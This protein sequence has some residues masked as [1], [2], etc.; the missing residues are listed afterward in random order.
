VSIKELKTP[1][2]A[3]LYAFMESWVYFNSNVTVKLAVQWCLWGG[4]LAGNSKRHD[5]LLASAEDLKLPGGFLMTEMHHGSNTRALETTATFDPATG[6]FVINTPHPGARKFWIGGTANDAHMGTVFARLIMPNGEDKGLHAF[7]VPL[8]N[9]TTMQLVSGVSIWDCGMKMGLNGVDNGCI[10]FDHVRVPRESLMNS[11]ADVDAAGR[12]VCDT[13]PDTRFGRTISE[14]SG[15]RV[16]ISGG[17]IVAEKTCLTIALRWAAQRKQFGP[18]NKDEVSILTYPTLQR[19]LL[20]PLCRVLV[21]DIVH[22]TVTDIYVHRH[23]AQGAPSAVVHALTAGLKAVNTW[24]MV[25][26]V[27]ACRESMG[28]QGF[29]S[30]NRVSEYVDDTHTFVTFE[31]VN[32]VLMQQVSR[33][34]LSQNKKKGAASTSNKPGVSVSADICAYGLFTDVAFVDFLLKQRENQLVAELQRRLSASKDSWATWTAELVL[35]ER[36]AF[37]FMD[38]YFHSTVREFAES[39]KCPA[40]VRPVLLHALRVTSLNAILK[41]F[42]TFA[43]LGYLPSRFTVQQADDVL[44]RLLLDVAPV[45]LDITE[46]FAVPEKCLPRADLCEL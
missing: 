10:Q 9:P 18:P 46:A 20:I 35:V 7:V 33:F 44:G 8:R 23:T 25:A 39:P 5:H 16:M 38:W 6:E 29:R 43:Q 41:D 4:S 3:R 13:D 27:S 36:L 15:G 28:G 32:T 21:A 31:G 34:V 37:A 2:A 17:S 40:S 14:L 24:A 19:T 42:G 11:Y 26:T 22:R 12:Y 45:A 1:T 30:K